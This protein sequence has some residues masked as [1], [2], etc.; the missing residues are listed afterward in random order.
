M[1]EFRPSLPLPPSQAAGRSASAIRNG[2]NRGRAIRSSPTGYR[3]HHPEAHHPALGRVFCESTAASI[4]LAAGRARPASSLEG[5][6]RLRLLQRFRRSLC[7]IRRA[8]RLPAVSDSHQ[9]RSGRLV[10]RGSRNLV[11][12]EKSHQRCSV[13]KPPPRH[14]NQLHCISLR[15]RNAKEMPQTRS[16]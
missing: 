16:C 13:R 2:S 14:L 6:R 3:F 5:F 8:C 12:S 9:P 4:Y 11:S 10:L 7:L 1:I 15:T